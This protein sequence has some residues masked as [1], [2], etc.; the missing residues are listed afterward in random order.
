MSEKKIDS[1][2]M[3]KGRDHLAFLSLAEQQTNQL[4][5]V[6]LDKLDA[7]CEVIGTSMCILYQA[8]TCYRKCSGGSHVLESLIGRAYNL[9]C[10]AYILILRGF[11]D[12]AMN[13]IRSLG[14]IANLWMLLSGQGTEALEW[15][16][17]DEKERKTKFSPLRVR[18]RLEEM[19]KP[20]VATESWY[21]DYCERFTH[22]TPHTRPN[23]YD[24]SI[25]GIAGGVLQKEGLDKSIGDLASIS[26]SLALLIAHAF[27]FNDLWEALTYTI[28]NA[29]DTEK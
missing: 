8:A 18:M 23:Q 1:P 20:L 16:N 29:G 17:A 24:Q 15:L 5:L 3:L 7:D 25:T 11:Y 22:V 2:A 9:C 26:G 4:T 14:E 13:L 28:E 6:G 27:K 21:K 19:E 10:S 12:E